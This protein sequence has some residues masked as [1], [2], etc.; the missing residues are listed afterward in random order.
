MCLFL[1]VQCFIFLELDNRCLRK[2]DV[3]VTYALLFIYVL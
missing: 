1:S 2:L 3:F